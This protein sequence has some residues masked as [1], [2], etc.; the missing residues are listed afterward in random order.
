MV[1]QSNHWELS[2][3]QGKNTKISLVL[4]NFIF[5]EHHFHQ[6]KSNI[7]TIYYLCLLLIKVIPS[8]S[9]HFDKLDFSKTV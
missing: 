9:V 7:V 4:L 8:K 3:L 1:A 6:Q 5:A 2:P